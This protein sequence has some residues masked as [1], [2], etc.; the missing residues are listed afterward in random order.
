MCLVYNYYYAYIARVQ[1]WQ[2][3]LIS[4]WQNNDKTSSATT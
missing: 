3:H 1:F 4:F 2:F